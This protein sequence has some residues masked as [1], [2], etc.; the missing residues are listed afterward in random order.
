MELLRSL[1]AAQIIRSGE[2]YL[3]DF[4]DMSLQLNSRMALACVE[5]NKAYEIKAIDHIHFG[6]TLVPQ[7]AVRLMKPGISSTVMQHVLRRSK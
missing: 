7:N 4:C 6:I 1:N 3:W 5:E 2:P